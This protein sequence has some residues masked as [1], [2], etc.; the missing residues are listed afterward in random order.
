VPDEPEAPRTA[1]AE[2]PETAAPAV[3][4]VPV[5]APRPEDTSGP[6][7]LPGREP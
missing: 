2:L 6:G 3:P 7:A 5:E 4:D 1:E